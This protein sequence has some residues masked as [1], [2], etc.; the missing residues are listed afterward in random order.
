[1]TIICIWSR[2]HIPSISRRKR[3]TKKE[4]FFK[5]YIRVSKL[6]IPA[7]KDRSHSKDIPIHSPK[8]KRQN[9]QAY[10]KPRRLIDWFLCF[11]R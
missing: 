5:K 6:Y 9:V 2:I 11:L 1:M 10:T 8:E 7:A 4:I 3:K